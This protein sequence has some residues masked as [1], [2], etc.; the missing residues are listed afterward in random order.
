MTDRS[1]T[2]PAV[3]PSLPL[4]VTV[5]PDRAAP[6]RVADHL[7]AAIGDRVRRDAE[8]VRIAVHETVANA[9][10]HGGPPLTVTA[11]LDDRAVTVT[12]ADAGRGSDLTPRRSD[13]SRPAVEQGR[14]MASIAATCDGVRVER[15][16]SGGTSVRLRFAAVTAGR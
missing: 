3:S 13:P 9:V 12:V 14:G 8:D 11:S 5:D 16:P 2:E 4:T 15:T 1:V 10:L 6:R 7:V